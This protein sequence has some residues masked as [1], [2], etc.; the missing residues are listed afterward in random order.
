MRSQTTC[1]LFLGL[2]AI[3]NKQEEVFVYTKTLL[4]KDFELPQRGFFIRKDSVHP[5]TVM[6]KLKKIVFSLNFH[7]VSLPLDVYNVE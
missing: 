3:P 7:I 1:G 5:T 6:I 2:G 4:A